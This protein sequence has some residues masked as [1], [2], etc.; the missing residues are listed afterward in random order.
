MTEPVKRNSHR[1]G[2]VRDAVLEWI[3][4]FPEGEEFHYGS[5]AEDLGV[6]LPT[7]S[8]TMLK[9]V[10]S[11]RSGVTYGSRSGWY[12]KTA[13]DTG[14]KTN[15]TAPVKASDLLEVVGMMKDGSLLLR[16]ENGLLYKA[17]EL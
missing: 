15:L 7:I 2:T 10:R 9:I 1:Y 11:G 3:R 6:Q 17:E 14:Q 8:G 12:R 5:I 13:A 16:A 4:Q